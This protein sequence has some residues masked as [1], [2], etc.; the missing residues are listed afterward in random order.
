MTGMVGSL[1]ATEV[2]KLLLGVGEPLVGRLLLVDALNGEFRMVK[3][4]RNPDCP[5][6]GDN[7]TVTELIDYEVFCGLA[8]APG[9]EEAVPGR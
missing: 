4:R 7:P 1:Q 2:V 8:P 9:P 3:T 5:L 6:C